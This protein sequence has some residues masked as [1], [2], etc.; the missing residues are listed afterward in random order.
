MP[1]TPQAH[2]RRS[3]GKASTAT[4]A[5]QQNRPQHRHPLPVSPAHAAH[6]RRARNTPVEAVSRGHAVKIRERKVPEWTDGISTGDVI[7]ALANNPSLF[8]LADTIPD[9]PKRTGGRPNLYPAWVYLV[10]AALISWCGSA[11]KAA[12]ELSSE[13]V[14]RFLVDQVGRRHPERTNGIAPVGPRRDHWAYASE[15]IRDY[16]DALEAKFLEESVAQAIQQGCFQP[17]KFSLHHPK[18][19]NFVIGDGKVFTPLTRATKAQELDEVTGE[20]VNRRLDPAAS[21]YKEGGNDE[22]NEADETSEPATSVFGPKYVAVTVR[23]DS[24]PLTRITLTRSFHPKTGL[25][26]EAGIG[27][28]LIDA[29]HAEVQHQNGQMDGAVWDGAMSGMHHERALANGYVLI[30]PTTA[31]RNP[32]GRSHLT[33]GRKPK[34][35]SLGTYTYDHC[36]NAETEG[37]ND[38]RCSSRC[39]HEL[40]ASDGAPHLAEDTIDGTV[41]TPLWFETERHLRKTKSPTWYHEV[42]IPCER[43]GEHAHDGERFHVVRIHL[44]QQ[45]QDTTAKFNRAEYLRAVPRG[46]PEYDATYRAWRPDIESKNSQDENAFHLRRMP[47]LGEQQQ[48]LVLL[49]LDLRQNSVS[50][51]IHDGTLVPRE[52]RL[53]RH[54]VERQQRP[55]CP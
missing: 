27:M 37:H 28:N 21:Y 5:P 20:L 14:W 11:S 45:P 6:R 48:R 55:P 13:H 10:F 12:S 53:R 33:K 52:Q 40:F 4:R 15:F 44:R 22:P 54:L 26:G 9:I 39:E 8:A 19:G 29:I 24:R 25:G 36:E 23:A 49:G 16:L 2:P 32:G 1:Y 31:L 30:S 47:A 17:G 50:R 41:L 51:A 34:N 35:R 3:P 42:R 46:T 18:R 38:E 43:N 7:V